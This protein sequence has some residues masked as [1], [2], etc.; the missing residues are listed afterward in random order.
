MRRGW[1]I[2][3]LLLALREPQ[4]P[5]LKERRDAAG[6]RDLYSFLFGSYDFQYLEEYRSYVVNNY[7]NKSYADDHCCYFKYPYT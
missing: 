1:I 7:N 3:Y 5:P 6:T 4:S 2:G